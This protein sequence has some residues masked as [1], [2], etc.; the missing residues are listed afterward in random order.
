MVGPTLLQ[1][2][3]TGVELLGDDFPHKNLE[4]DMDPPA[5]FHNNLGFVCLYCP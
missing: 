5:H 1:N 2:I 4:W 3:S